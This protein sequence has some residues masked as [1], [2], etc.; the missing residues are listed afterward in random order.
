MYKPQGGRRK[1]TK[2]CGMFKARNEFYVCDSRES[3]CERYYIVKGEYYKR[4]VWEYWYIDQQ[5]IR[6]SCLYVH[7]YHET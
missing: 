1:I 6:H 4:E 5:G 3:E 7:R 2:W